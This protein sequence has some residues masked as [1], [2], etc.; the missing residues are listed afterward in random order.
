MALFTNAW[1]QR[2]ISATANKVVKKDPPIVVSSVTTNVSSSLSTA[3]T[4]YF[5]KI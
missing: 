4:T 5:Y 2:N 3:P 1:E